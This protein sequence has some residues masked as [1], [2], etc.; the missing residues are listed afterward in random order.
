[1]KIIKCSTLLLAT[2][3]SFS[4]LITLSS[5]STILFQGFNWESCNKQGG[6]YNWLRNSVDQI[7][8]AGVTHVW[9]PPPT[10]SV[11]P[12]G[13]LPGKLYDLD[14]SRYGSGADLKALIS[15]FHQKGIKCM[16]DIVINH[17][18]GTKQDGRG[19]WCIFEGG[20]SDGRLNWGPHFICRDDTQYSDGSGNLDSGA[21]YDAAPDIDHLNPTVQ[22][23]LT[24]WMNWLKAEIG[25]DGWRFDFAKGYAASV[26]K[27]Y[28]EGTSPNFAVGEIWNSISYGQDGKPNYN[29]D[30]HRNELANWVGA[31]GGAIAAF[32]FTTKGILQAA[33]EGEWWRMKDPNARP[34]GLIGILPQNA[35]TFIDNHDTGSTQRLWPFPSDK[36]M[37]GYA[38]ILTHP[39]VPAVFYDHFF[40]WGL[41]E[42]I[43]ALTEVRNRN[44][45]NEASSVNIMASDADLYV[46]MIDGKIIVKIGPRYNIGN[47]ISSNFKI[48]TSGQDYCVWEKQQ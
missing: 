41:M 6:W 7:A 46:A 1:M 36:V 12:Q 8:R 21:A 16:A 40:D 42:G 33:V 38:Y 20:T 32:D 43:I 9:L 15:T 2:L 4:L 28:M 48:V 24:D 30:W 34:P 13:Y 17:R 10:H 47:L 25:F 26:M 14:E 11:S 5:A 23:D 27:T 22:K 44:G 19:I 31:A 37:L 35:V 18:C 45:I 29:Q 3:C 39:G